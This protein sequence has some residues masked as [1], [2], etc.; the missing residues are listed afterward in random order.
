M[1]AVTIHSHSGAQENKVCYCFHY[2][3]ICLPWR[4]GTRCHDLRFFECWVL[5]QL[6]H[7]PLSHSS[8]GF[9]VPLHFL[10]KGGVICISEVIDI[11]PGNHDSSPTFLMMYSAYQ[12]NKQGDN[13]QPWRTPFPIWNQSVVPCP[14][15]TVASWPANRFLKRQVRWSA[16]PISVRIFQFVVIH[17][18]QGFSIVNEAEVDVCLFF[19]WNSYFFYDPTNVGNLISGPFAFSKSSLYIWKFLVH[20]LLKPILKDFEHNITSMWNEHNCMVVW[21]FFGI[22]PLWDWNEKWSFPVLWSPQSFPN[23]LTYW[24]QHFNS[25]IF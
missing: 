23:L 14:V 1:A 11:S 9:L 13:I 21:T 17:T 3:C 7:S 4:K 2:F 24:V 6:F 18:V 10:H 20:I 5:S 12:L 8:R 19:F 15:L 25:V 22:T 16:I